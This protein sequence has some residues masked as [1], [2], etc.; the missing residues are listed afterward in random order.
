MLTD[1]G[2]ASGDN[3]DYQRFILVI[4]CRMQWDG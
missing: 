3:V 4:A 1:G 2:H